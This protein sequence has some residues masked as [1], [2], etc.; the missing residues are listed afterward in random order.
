M[1]I[2]RVST[3]TDYLNVGDEMRL[4]ISASGTYKDI[5][6]FLNGELFAV[7]LSSGEFSFLQC[8]DLKCKFEE[9]GKRLVIDSVTTL[10][11][12]I[13]DAKLFEDYQKCNNSD[14]SGCGGELVTFTRNVYGE[15][16]V[17]HDRPFLML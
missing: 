5:G 17:Y 4:E 2:N 7:W 9:Y 1:V 8:P 12:G 11:H 13:Y 14:S 6:W 16:S 15:C 3:E 10:H